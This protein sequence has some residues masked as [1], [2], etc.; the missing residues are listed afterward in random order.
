[1]SQ[2]FSLCS[3]LL[4]EELSSA[5]CYLAAVSLAWFREVMTSDQTD[6][7]VTGSV[8]LLTSALGGTAAQVNSLKSILAFE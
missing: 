3:D 5:V 4:G 8:E 6:D 1:M 7:C 2:F